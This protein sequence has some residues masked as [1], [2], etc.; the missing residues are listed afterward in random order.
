[1]IMASVN[2]KACVFGLI[3]T[4]SVGLM[5]L[6]ARAD[7]DA[8]VEQDAS[9]S[10]AVIGDGNAAATAN[11][12]TAEILQRSRG[13][14]FDQSNNGAATRQR[15]DQATGVSGYGNAVGTDNQ[16]NVRIDQMK[17][18]VHPVIYPRY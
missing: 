14:I 12:Q 9:Q 3:A 5:A 16:Q 6:P 8:I 4:A 2:V 1:M 11:Q 7:N 17:K 15:V 10:T 18:P 13:R